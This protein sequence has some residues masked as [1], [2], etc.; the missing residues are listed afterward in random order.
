MRLALGPQQSSAPERPEQSGRW[1]ALQQAP[2]RRRAMVAPA[3]APQRG[4]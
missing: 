4:L 1:R 3:N 2:A